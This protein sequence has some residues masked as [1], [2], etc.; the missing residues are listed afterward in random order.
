MKSRAIVQTGVR[1]LEL[2]EFPLPEIG[3]DD[4]LLKVDACGICDAAGGV[5]GCS[6]PVA[7]WL[8]AVVGAGD[9]STMAIGS[10]DLSG[11]AGALTGAGAAA[12]GSGGIVLSDVAGA[13]PSSTAV[14]ACASVD[15]ASP[16]VRGVSSVSAAA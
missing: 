4:G 7:G 11:V 2:R 10:E 14:S 3:D 13:T 15:S 6:A 8:G 16:A 5:T 1:A 9:G 12:A